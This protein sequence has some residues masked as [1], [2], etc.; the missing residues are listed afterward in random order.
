MK[1]AIHY[2]IESYQKAFTSWGWKEATLYQLWA[3]LTTIAGLSSAN[4]NATAWQQ[5]KAHEAAIKINHKIGNFCQNS[6]VKLE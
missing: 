2:V 3:N 6:Y 1:N 5:V 4:A